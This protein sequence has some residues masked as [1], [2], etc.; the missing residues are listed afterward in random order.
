MVIVNTY[1]VSVSTENENFQSKHMQCA[2]FA[3]RR[4]RERMIHGCICWNGNHF[5]ISSWSSV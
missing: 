5:K 4:N 2:M 1:S 3:H